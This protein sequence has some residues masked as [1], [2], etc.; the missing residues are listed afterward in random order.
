MYPPTNMEV[1]MLMIVFV[2]YSQK[3]QIQYIYINILPL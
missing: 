2:S 1:Q 3:N